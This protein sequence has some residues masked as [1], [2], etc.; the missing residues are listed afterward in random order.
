MVVDIKHTGIQSTDVDDLGD[1]HDAEKPIACFKLELYKPA[2]ENKNTSESWRNLKAIHRRLSQSVQLAV[3]NV[4]LHVGDLRAAGKFRYATPSERAAE[5]LWK[6]Y[7][8]EQH[9]DKAAVALYSDGHAK[10]GV[11]LPTECYNEDDLFKTVSIVTD[12]LKTSETTEYLYGSVARKLCQS[13]FAGAKFK[14]LLKGENAFP[15]VNRVGIMIRARDWRVETKMRLGDNGKKYFDVLVETSAWQK[16]GGK[17][18]LTC[19]ALHGGKLSRAIPLLEELQ[20]AGF[21]PRTAKDWKKGALTIRPVRRPGQPE[22]WQILLPYQPKRPDTSGEAKMVVHRSVVN[23]LTAA[24]KDGDRVKVHHYPGLAV[25]L[26]KSQMYA[27]RRGVA[28]DLAARLHPMRQANRRHY[29][30]MRRL[31]DAEARAT[32]T[33]L[34][35]AAKWCEEIAKKAGAKVVYIDDFTSFDPDQPGPPWEPFI[36]RFPWSDLKLKCIDAVTRRAG[37]P[38]Q[39]LRSHYI[40][41]RCPECGFTDKANIAKMP[42]VRGTHVERGIFHCGKCGC[43]ADVDDIASRNELALCEAQ[44]PAKNEKAKA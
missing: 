22:K 33:E 8:E 3:R 7:C 25:V 23:M 32:Q 13:E 43:E 9:P 20:S 30:A 42:V 4:V 31:A 5:A 37:I 15:A 26:L 14:A 28:R 24:V 36:R 16:G 6:E 11:P 40:S 44:P 41:Q 29:K 2:F 34:W 19:K 18:Q 38:V 17:V 12:A 27:R 21:D 1:F 39:E 35:R 10:I